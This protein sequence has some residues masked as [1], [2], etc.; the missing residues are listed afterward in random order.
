MVTHDLRATADRAGLGRPADTFL[1][2]DPEQE[3]V[4]MVW[5]QYGAFAAYE[6][7]REFQTIVYE[8]LE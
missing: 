1:W 5:M 6:I 8:S 3:L 4:G 7:E 2:L